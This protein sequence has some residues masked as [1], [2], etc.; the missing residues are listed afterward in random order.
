MTCWNPQ[1]YISC[2]NFTEL[3][4]GPLS[5]NGVADTM[6]TEPFSFSGWS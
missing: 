5:M 3:N 6:P 2:L 1:S 4:Q